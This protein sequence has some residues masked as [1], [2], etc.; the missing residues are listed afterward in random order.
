MTRVI[1]KQCDNCLKYFCNKSAL[2]KHKRRKRPCKKVEAVEEQEPK[3]AELE[4]VSV[5][6]LE[7]P[8]SVPSVPSVPSVA[9]NPLTE[10]DIRHRD[11]MEQIQKDIASIKWETLDKNTFDFNYKEYGRSL[12]CVGSSFQGKTTLCLKIMDLYFNKKDV[13][14]VCMLDNPQGSIYDGL[15]RSYL[16]T[17]RFVNEIPKAM[18]KINKKMNNRYYFTVM[19]DDIL[20]MRYSTTLRSMLL[21]WRNSLINSLISLQHMT[22]VNASMRNSV[23]YFCFRNNTALDVVET[24]MKGYLGG[25]GIFFKKKTMLEKVMLYQEILKD[26]S[27]TIVLDNIKGE[28]RFIEYKI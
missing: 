21:S 20:D 2:N 9:H 22:L 6:E 27:K 23:S 14:N 24:I 13:I 5:A 17:D 26:K 19:T 1:K 7:E 8:I 12:I 15:P 28:L 18:H 16:V 25:R 3:E 10:Q 11:I 4:A